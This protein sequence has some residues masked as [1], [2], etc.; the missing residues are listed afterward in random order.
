M[1]GRAGRRRAGWLGRLTQRDW[2]L[3]LVP[4]RWYVAVSAGA[5]AVA[6]AS[7]VILLLPH[8]PPRAMMAD[9]RVPAGRP[10]RPASR[11]PARSQM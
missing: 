9:S 5:G 3:A 10:L 11:W 1:P 6:L 8:S 4:Y 2:Y 7:G